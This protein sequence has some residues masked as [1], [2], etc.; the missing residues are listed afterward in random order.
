MSRYEHRYRDRR[1]KKALDE[2][3]KVE[4]VAV[5]HVSAMVEEYGQFLRI[6]RGKVRGWQA[7]NDS[8]V[9]AIR[10]GNSSAGDQSILVA[11]FEE[12]DENKNGK[13]SPYELRVFLGR[14]RAIF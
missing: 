1:K 6:F 5:K 12:V 3:S 11:I 10:V 4:K 13:I 8:Q 14:R 7:V 9:N 2:D